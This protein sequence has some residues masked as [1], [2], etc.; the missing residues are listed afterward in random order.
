MITAATHLTLFVND[1]DE[2]KK[3]YTE[4]LGFTVHTDA[5]MGDMRWLTLNP[6]E[7]KNFEL[8][9]FLAAQEDKSLVGKQGGSGILL[10]LASDNLDQDYKELKTKGVEFIGEP[11]EQDWGK[12]VTFK[13]LYGNLLYLVQPPA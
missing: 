5:N 11:E 2:A 7:Q 6:K 13:D 8:V 9:L 4:K 1:Q 12:S 3:F 10:C